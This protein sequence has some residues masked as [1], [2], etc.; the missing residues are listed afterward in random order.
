MTTTP[1]MPDAVADALERITHQLSEHD[2]N[3][4]RVPDHPDL[5]ANAITRDRETITN[6]LAQDCNSHADALQLAVVIG[7]HLGEV[8]QRVKAAGAAA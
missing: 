1:P 2:A 7:C 4:E 8:D 3:P 5:Y 6:W